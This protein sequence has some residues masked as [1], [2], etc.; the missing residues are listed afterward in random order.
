VGTATSVGVADGGNQTIVGVG[1]VVSVGIGVAVDRV[2]PRG[3]Q[4]T[5]SRSPYN[6]RKIRAD[7]IKE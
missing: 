5:E 7:F 3:R 4:A 6:R 2:A 1:V